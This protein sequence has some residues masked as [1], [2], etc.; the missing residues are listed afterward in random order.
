M[1]ILPAQSPG[2]HKISENTPSLS[3][4]L[5][6]SGDRNSARAGRPRHEKQGVFR[7]KQRIFFASLLDDPRVGFCEAK[8]SRDVGDDDLRGKKAN[9]EAA[10]ARGIDGFD[11]KWSFRR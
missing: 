5:Y 9:G 11:V 7:E 10:V 3:I 4:H 1:G 6:A 2:G 8:R